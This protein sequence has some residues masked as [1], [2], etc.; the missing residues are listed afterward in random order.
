MFN[1]DTER[2][3]V[4]ISSVV[5]RGRDRDHVIHISAI[6]GLLDFLEDDLHAEL[7]LTGGGG[8]L[9]EGGGQGASVAVVDGV[10]L[11]SGVEEPGGEEVGVVEDV[12]ELSAE[13]KFE[14]LG[15]ERDFGV[16]EDGHI[17]GGEAWSVEAVASGVS[18][19][20]GAELPAGGG[21]GALIAGRIWIG[22]GGRRR[23]QEGVGCAAV[24]V[25]G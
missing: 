1:A 19:D 10:V 7:D 24:E 25:G 15:D 22:Y 18:D 3:V 12:E 16:L 17:E 6:G 13:L 4:S 2:T 20:I 9:V 23:G 11:A 21:C 5:V 14:G 8:G